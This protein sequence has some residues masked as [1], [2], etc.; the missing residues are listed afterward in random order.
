MALVARPACQIVHPDSIA[1]CVLE[2]YDRSRTVVAL[3]SLWPF[4]TAVTALLF[5]ST[6]S[7]QISAS[8]YVFVRLS[9]LASSR[10][11]FG[12]PSAVQISEDIPLCRF[13]VELVEVRG[14]PF[15]SLI[16][17]SGREKLEGLIGM[18]RCSSSWATSLSCSNDRT[19]ALIASSNIEALNNVDLY[20][21]PAIVL[22][23]SK[24]FLVICT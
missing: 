1:G 19:Q 18:S 17:L 23:V 15:L 2:G 5:F 3:L 11:A 20:G 14:I 10:G 4:K 9:L 8:T 16:M 7:A 21:I 12:S 22:S 13:E 6:W 24:T